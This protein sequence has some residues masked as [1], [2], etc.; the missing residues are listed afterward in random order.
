[1]FKNF[2]NLCNCF[3]S[4]F[5]IRIFNNKS[6]ISFYIRRNTINKFCVIVNI[7]FRNTSSNSIK[8]F[9]T[10]SIYFVTFLI[11]YFKTSNTIFFLYLNFRNNFLS[12]S[13]IKS[14]CCSPI[15]S[16]KIS[17]NIKTSKTRK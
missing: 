1:M 3:F 4:K 16:K 7:L 15:I 12:K 6:S 5:T 13:S 8:Q 14:K 9:L 10:K 2:C 17:K 11:S